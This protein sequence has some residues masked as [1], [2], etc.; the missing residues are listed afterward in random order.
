VYKK[1]ITNTAADC[2]SRRFYVPSNTDI[3]DDI[4]FLN[5]IECEQDLTPSEPKVKRKQKT[6]EIIYFNHA[7]PASIDATVQKT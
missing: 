6:Y 2:L 3:G 1:G 7:R 4:E 5:A